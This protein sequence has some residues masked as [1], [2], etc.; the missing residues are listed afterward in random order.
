MTKQELETAKQKMKEYRDIFGGELCRKDLIDE[1]E[2][3]IDLDDIFAKHFDFINDMA[4]D[5]ESSLSR[6]KREIGVC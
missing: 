4:R 3:I 6:F 1:A 2:S 5:A